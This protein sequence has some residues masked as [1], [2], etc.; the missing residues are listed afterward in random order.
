MFD[1]TQI[2]PGQTP[3]DPDEKSALIPGHIQFLWELNQY[4]S[5]NIRTA[6]TQF[7]EGRRRQWPLENPEF[8]KDIHRRMFGQTWKWAGEYRK[9]QKNLGKEWFRIPEE[10]KKTCDDFRFWKEKNSFPDLEIA[11]RFHYRLVAIH[12]FP[13]GNGRHAR[14][15]ADIFLRER[16]QKPLTWGTGENFKDNPNRAAYIAALK[17]ADEG[18]FAPLL[19]F[20]R[21]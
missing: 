15:V 11:V 7:L 19:S 17:K 3:L 6:E 12:P 20:A 16:K 9:T 1:L 18:D 21:S 4:E 14:L 5:D 10:V 2:L 8:L 13:N